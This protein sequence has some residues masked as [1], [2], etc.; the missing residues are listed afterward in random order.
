C[1]SSG[2]Q[3]SQKLSVIAHKPGSSD[4]PQLPGLISV[5]RGCGSFAGPTTSADEHHTSNGESDQGE[6]TC[7]TIEHGPFH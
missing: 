7:S 4:H 5:H 2:P 1:S 3:N 6:T